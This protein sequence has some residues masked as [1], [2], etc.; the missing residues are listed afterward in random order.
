M[1]QTDETVVGSI[2]NL[3]NTKAYWLK[4]GRGDGKYLFYNFQ[5]GAQY[6][7][8]NYGSGPTDWTKNDHNCWKFAIYKSTDTGKYY[9][10]SLGAEKFIGY[11]STN[12]AN[13]PLVPYPTNDI[14][15][16][17]ASMVADHPF[18]FSTDNHG[19][20]NVARTG[21]YGVVNW[22]NGASDLN[23]TGNAFKII[24]AGDLS[25]EVQ[26]AIKSKVEAAEAGI[27]LTADTRYN[28]KIKNAYLCNL[29]EASNPNR[30]RA[31]NIAANSNSGKAVLMLEETGL[32]YVYK[33]KYQQNQLQEEYTYLVYTQNNGDAETGLQVLTAENSQYA[34]NDKWYLCPTDDGMTF[35]IRPY[36]IGSH[37]NLWGG[38]APNPIGLYG[39]ESSAHNVVFEAADITAE[40]AANAFP[41]YRESY[42]NNVTWSNTRE[43]TI[44][45]APASALETAKQEAQ[46]ASSLIDCANILKESN[47]IL[48]PEA[49][50]YYMIRNAKVEGE[51]LSERYDLLQGGNYSLYC[52]PLATNTTPSLWQFERMTANGKKHLINIKNANS[53]LYMSKSSWDYTMRLLPA[54]GEIGEFDLGSKSWIDVDGAIN[55]WDPTHDGTATIQGDG[56]VKTWKAT[57]SENNFFIEEVSEIPVTVG[58][59]GY[60]TLNLPFAVTVHQ[61]VTAYTATEGETEVTLSE[62]SG[63]VIP[64]R[65]PVI[66]MANAGTYQFAIAYDETAGPLTT[67]LSG[68]LVPETI[69]AEATAYVLKQGQAG[70]G[71]Y[72]VNSE[73]D[74]TIG[75]NKAYLGSTNAP[76]EAK[77]FSLNGD[78]TGIHGAE[79]ADKAPEAYY[80][81]TGRRVLYPAHG[82]FVKS[83]GQKVFI[84]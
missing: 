1:A 59:A 20:I 65:T 24:E 22:A 16:G 58:A 18:V 80:D 47:H 26:N 55:L 82:V 6:L 5:S 63:N 30:L 46:N 79:T 42:I 73:T 11:A 10:Y 64:A 44:G 66:L 56:T 84:K 70:I 8:S 19:R 45:Y 35:K 9:I 28:V 25:E 77:R 33:I 43:N 21:N 53:D 54:N 62:I 37:W 13:V 15:I 7:S 75:A 36:H 52:A 29:P 83:N 50:K 68:T 31:Y 57:G 72:L 34:A 71:M 4:S 27:A 81:L 39:D 48:L 78:A 61:D 67:V 74:R 32:N 41:T 76:V 23:D 38:G 14:Q 51:Y 40:A 3:Q 49:G 12:D 2:E 60:A 69:A 17:T